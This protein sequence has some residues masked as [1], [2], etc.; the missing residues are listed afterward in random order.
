M[1]TLSRIK[2][3]EVNAGRR[4]VGSVTVKDLVTAMYGEKI[5]ENLREKALEPFMDEALRKLAEDGQVA[6]EMRGG[7]KKWFC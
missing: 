4:K 5:D 3:Q 2:R 7:V 6:F 1:Q